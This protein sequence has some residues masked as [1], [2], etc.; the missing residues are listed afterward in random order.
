MP[1]T[2]AKVKA[3]HLTFNLNSSLSEFFSLLGWFKTKV[4][5][6]RRRTRSLR[7]ALPDLVFQ[8]F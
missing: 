1:L 3:K 8:E 6:W 4:V 2:L 5:L 7:V